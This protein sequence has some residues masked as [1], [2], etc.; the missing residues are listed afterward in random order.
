MFPIPILPHWMLTTADV[1]DR[2]ET[3]S[4]AQLDIGG[5]YCHYEAGVYHHHTS[6]TPEYIPTGRQAAGLVILRA[7]A[8]GAEMELVYAGFPPA[9]RRPWVAYPDTQGRD[10][11]QLD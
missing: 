5:G 7:A 6:G 11:D 1:L 4:H 10:D 2:L 9:I 3:S 8:E